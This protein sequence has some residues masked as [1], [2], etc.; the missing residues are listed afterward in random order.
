MKILGV[1]SNKGV[2]LDE[3]QDIIGDSEDFDYIGRVADILAK[4][5]PV[6]QPAHVDSGTST[7]GGK[8]L[9]GMSPMELTRK[10]Y[11]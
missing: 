5:A 3:L 6:E 4:N 10:A 1:V 7:G 9:S 8:S 2:S 11:N